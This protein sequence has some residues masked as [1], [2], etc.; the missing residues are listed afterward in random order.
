M[1]YHLK[2][3]RRKSVGFVV[4][5]D[6]LVVTAPRWV[7]QSEIDKL[8]REKA[9]WLQRKLAEQQERRKRVESLVSSGAMAPP[10]PSW[11]SPCA[12]S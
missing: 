2:R 5:A 8:L 12:W 6:G 4:S 3:A 11:V 9:A 1:A 7:G 10:C